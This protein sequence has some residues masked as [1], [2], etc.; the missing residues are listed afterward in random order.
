MFGKG[1]ING[2]RV[3]LGHL[4][5]KNITQQYPEQHPKLPQRSRCSFKLDSGKCISCGIC[6]LSCPNKVIAIDSYKDENNKRQ[7]S[8]YEMELMYCL[9]C[10]LCIESCPSKAL[11]STSNFELST[12]NKAETKL[13]LFSS[14]EDLS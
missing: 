1:L 4:F 10:G 9:F 8:K 5:E 3:T 7:L 12:C 14:Q 6:A 2:L 11:Q 13:T